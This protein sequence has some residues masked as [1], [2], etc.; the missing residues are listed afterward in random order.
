M[1]G[2]PKKGL[3]QL[4]V[5]ALAREVGLPKQTVSELMRRGRGPD[6]IRLYASMREGRSAQKAYAA[7]T[8]LRN[9][10]KST[11]AGDEYECVL[12]GRERLEAID[13][14]KLRRAKA[15]A[16]HQEQENARK[17]GQLV[18]I[19]YIHKWGTRFLVDARDELLRGPSDL[20]DA[21]AAESDP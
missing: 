8:S 7:V 1:R 15:L 6:E 13:D 10:P 14:A 4:G 12:R 11:T 20:Q 19:S 21:L 9:V 18:P 5:N 3:V 17:R 16:E 2:Q